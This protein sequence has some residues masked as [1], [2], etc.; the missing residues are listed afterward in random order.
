MA[1]TSVPKSRHLACGTG[2]KAPPPT[3]CTLPVL[4]PSCNTVH[5]FYIPPVPP[6]I[7]LV[8]NDFIFF[9]GVK[10][11]FDSRYRFP[12]GDTPTRMPRRLT[13]AIFFRRRYCALQQSQINWAP[14][15]Y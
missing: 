14:P 10:T 4:P 12:Q 3:N 5:P 15:P 13:C 7:P 1:A 2:Q 11:C 8:L 6:A 9:K